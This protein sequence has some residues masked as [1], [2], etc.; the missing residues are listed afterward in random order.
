[1]ADEEPLHSRPGTM[2][3][4]LP[5]SPIGTPAETVIPS[6]GSIHR[7]AAPSRC[8]GRR[9]RDRIHRRR[10][11]DRP[12]SSDPL[13]WLLAARSLPDDAATTSV[14]FRAGRVR[15]SN[16]TAPGMGRPGWWLGRPAPA[17]Q[18]GVR[19]AATGAAAAAAARG[20]GPCA[21]VGGTP[22]WWAAAGIR[23]AAL[24][25]GVLWAPRLLAPPPAEGA[26][27]GNEPTI[28]QQKWVE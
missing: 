20:C 8:R 7:A 14:R 3:G 18:A 15:C 5:H 22:A 19:A 25:A 2:T 9:R 28:R 11:P 4:G 26:C 23:S 12:V 13:G 17:A 1:M 16:A 6:A 21:T 24:T 27:C 10:D